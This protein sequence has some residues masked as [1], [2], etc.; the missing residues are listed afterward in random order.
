M[1]S[2]LRNF[3]LYMLVVNTDIVSSFAPPT[4]FVQHHSRS[5]SQGLN[6]ANTNSENPVS[7]FLGNLFSKETAP[8]EEE[9][10]KIPDFVPDPEY[11]VGAAFLVFGALFIA[12]VPSLV[13]DVLFGGFFV[14]LGAIF[15]LQATRIRVLFD[16]STFSIQLGT[17][18]NED[19]LKSSGKN[20]VVGG[21]N[22]WSYDSFVNWEFFP[23]KAFPVLI[24]FKENQTPSVSSVFFVQQNFNLSRIIYSFFFN[25]PT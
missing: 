6:M 18:E 23:N 16:E 7:S 22:R 11:K 12:T 14:L 5:T 10:P 17:N 1:I 3:L 24:Y 15:V 9:K 20:F 21:E 8:V 25:F 2:I 4:T 13:A 19:G